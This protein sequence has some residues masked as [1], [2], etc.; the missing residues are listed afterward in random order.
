MA[1]VA[2]G[3]RKALVSTGQAFFFTNWHRKHSSHVGAPFLAL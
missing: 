3:S 1:A 2:A